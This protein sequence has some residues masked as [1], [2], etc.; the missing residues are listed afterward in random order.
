MS[1]KHQPDTNH[2]VKHFINSQTTNRAVHS[3]SSTLVFIFCYASVR[4]PIEVNTHFIQ[5]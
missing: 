1:A 5:P 2:I 3:S 4:I